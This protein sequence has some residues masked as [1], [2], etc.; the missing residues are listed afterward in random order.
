MRY[1][2]VP[3]FD[4]NTMLR[5]IAYVRKSQDRSDRQ[6][7]SIEGQINEIKRFAKQNGYVIVDIVIEKQSAKKPGRPE[8][9]TMIERIQKGE[10]NG[11]LCWKL[12]RLARNPVDAGTISWM[13]Q[14]NV[15]K[16]IHSKERSYLPTDNVLMM[17][18][19]FGIANQFIKDLSS[20][21]KRGMRDKANKGWNPQSSLPIGYIHNPNKSTGKEVICDPQRF[22]IVKE[23]W[24]RYETGA[25]S[26]LDIKRFADAMGLI[27]RN[28]KPYALNSYSLMFENPMYYGKFYWKDENGVPVLWE[29]KHTPMISE[30]TFRKV[31]QIKRL[32]NRNS[33][34]KG[35]F[36]TYRG[37]ITCGGCDGHVT[38]ERTK[39][40]ICTLCKFKYSIITNETCSKC[41][42][43]LSKMIN[44]KVVQ[45]IYYRCSRR[46]NPNCKE[47]SIT[48]KL[49][50]KTIEEV[51]LNI[52]ISDEVYEWTKQYLKDHSSQNVVNQQFQLE[53]L[54]RNAN[55]I[56]TKLKGL[57]D[58]QL[59]GSISSVE[60]NIMRDEYNGKL[61]SLE[62]EI[63][64]IENKPIIYLAEQN[65]YLDFAK[66]CA[67][68][69]QNGNSQT[70]REITAYFCSNLI[71]M[72]KTLYFSTK[73]APDVL[74]SMQTI[75]FSNNQCSNI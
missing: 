70:K 5:F 38:A 4:L 57:I 18:I 58:L 25:Y 27:N 10:A 47:K 8:F 2:S 59:S 29:G 11:I 15:I 49:I 71:L 45:N 52:S 53:S 69:F 75:L 73:K 46:K 61:T 51:L 33:G 32:R 17:Q 40:V 41:G 68:R 13:L 9:N 64:E 30:A 36:Y 60:A 34:P 31:Q 26:L 3:L 44:P 12:N 37:L 28:G 6:V 22:A 63:F 14:G 1:H 21:V 48:E 74:S 62:N 65:T 43:P 39:Q 55:R 66:N 16:A 23:L 24:D 19:D 67:K 42:T 7:M 50:N 56:K 54:K 20:D 35:Y 72:N